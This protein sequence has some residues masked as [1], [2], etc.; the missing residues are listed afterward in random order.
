MR[1]CRFNSRLVAL[2]VG[3]QMSR[4]GVSPQLEVQEVPYHVVE[5]GAN[6]PG[7]YQPPT[8]L[9]RVGDAGGWSADHGHGSVLPI[10]F[11]LAVVGGTPTPRQQSSTAQTRRT[12]GI[13]RAAQAAR[14]VPG[15]DHDSGLTILTERGR[16]VLGTGMMYW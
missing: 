13:S 1:W 10:R 9:V 16:C 12:Q 11:N 7:W 5:A 3:E 8:G 15:I 2:V 6:R 14:G 4:V